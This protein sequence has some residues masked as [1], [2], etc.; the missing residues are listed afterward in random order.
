[1]KPS[2][3]KL[4]DA[5]ITVDY[6]VTASAVESPVGPKFL[7]ITDI[8]NG[9]V[10][11]NYVPWCE[12]DKKKAMKS[13]LESGDIVFARTGATTG[14]SYLIRECPEDSVF[15]SYLISK[16]LSVLRILL[17]LFS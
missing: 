3:M 8:Q 6:G 7:R 13:K 16:C 4:G 5:A 1:M 11:W 14:K 17:I 15:A 10:D 12:T 9:D 2:T